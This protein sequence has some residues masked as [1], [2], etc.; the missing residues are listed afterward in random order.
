MLQESSSPL[1]FNE[2]RGT[3]LR[4]PEPCNTGSISASLM[5]LVDRDSADGPMLFRRRS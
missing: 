2:G 1:D 4:W 3:P 5:D